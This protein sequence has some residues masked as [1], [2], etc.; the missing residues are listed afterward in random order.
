MATSSAGSEARRLVFVVVATGLLIV[1]F[2]VLLPVFSQGVSDHFMK[3]QVTP[4]I[5]RAHRAS[6][7]QIAMDRFMPKVRRQA[8]AL[9]ENVADQELVEMAVDVCGPF[10]DG[11]AKP[12]AAA[13]RVSGTLAGA[14]KAEVRRVVALVVDTVCPQSRASA[15]S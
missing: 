14:S 4:S 12:D 13:T 11:N 3:T 5:E 2:K 8:P 7:A 9:T 6:A 15:G 1:G 10:D